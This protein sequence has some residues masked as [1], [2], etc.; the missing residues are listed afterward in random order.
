MTST[1]MHA[2]Y[3]PASGLQLWQTPGLVCYGSV[4][5]LTAGGT[6]FASEAVPEAPPPGHPGYQFY[7]Q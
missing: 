7:K 2:V 6:G 5:D 4:Q 3:Q 1:A